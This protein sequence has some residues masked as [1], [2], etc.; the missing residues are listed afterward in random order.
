MY[1]FDVWLTQFLIAVHFWRSFCII[2]YH[3]LPKKGVFFILFDPIVFSFGFGGKT[4]VIR[5]VSLFFIRFKAVVSCSFSLG[6]LV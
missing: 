2:F 4:S 5:S 3:S 1:L 6:F